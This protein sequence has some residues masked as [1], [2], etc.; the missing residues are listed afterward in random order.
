MFKDYFDSSCAKAKIGT[1]AVAGS[2]VTA[3]AE[4]DC[5]KTMKGVCDK[6][7]EQYNTIVNACV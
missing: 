2:V 4:S 7:L 6:I 1:M 5:S 3:S